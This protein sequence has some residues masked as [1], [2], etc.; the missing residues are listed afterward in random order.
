MH[1]KIESLVNY[2]DHLT[3]VASILNVASHNAKKTQIMYQANLS[4]SVLQRYLLEVSS[5]SLISFDGQSQSFVLTQ[6]GR[7]FL[8][9]Y[10]ECAKNSRHI[11]KRLSEVISMRKTLEQLCLP[12]Q[13]S[14]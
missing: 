10:K 3:I 14:I 2:R 4:Y 12:S 8:N 5:A 6:K 13:A 11:E 9:A 1:W 7:E